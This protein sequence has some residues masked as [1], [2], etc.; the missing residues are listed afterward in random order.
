MYVLKKELEWRLKNE[1]QGWNV[2]YDE[3][4]PALS[5]Y[6]IAISEELEPEIKVSVT[7]NAQLVVKIVHPDVNESDVNDALGDRSK[8]DD[9]IKL[10]RLI[11]LLNGEQPQQKK[12]CRMKVFETGDVVVLEISP[13]EPNA[14]DELIDQ[15]QSHVK[16][17]KVDSDVSAEECDDG[18][19]P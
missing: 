17:E 14:Q 2:V 8:C 5:V 7:F 18:E 10:S 13:D 6:K 12:K 16:S 15:L 4:L 19:T 3:D 11:R 1:L 9:W